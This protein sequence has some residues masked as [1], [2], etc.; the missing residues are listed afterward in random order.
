M[1]G[2]A[3][4]SAHPSPS[5]AT[6]TL[7]PSESSTST[8]PHKKQRLSNSS[9]SLSR[10]TPLSSLKGKARSFDVASPT[11]T[12]SPAPTSLPWFAEDLSPDDLALVRDGKDVQGAAESLPTATP[13]EERRKKEIILG[14]RDERAGP[15]KRE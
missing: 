10:T 1:R 5:H 6:Q 12:G 14:G 11:G 7:A 8:H 13:A 4:T 2:A 9:T 15:E 3:S